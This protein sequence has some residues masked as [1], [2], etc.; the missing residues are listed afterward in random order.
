MAEQQQQQ[1]QQIFDDDVLIQY[2]LEKPSLPTEVGL[3][4]FN[5]L[6]QR[7]R[8]VSATISLFFLFVLLF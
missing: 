6:L 5:L 7:T 2:E 3:R 8:Q 4:E 1:Q